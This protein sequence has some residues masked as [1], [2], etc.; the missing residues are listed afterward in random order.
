MWMIV[1]LVG[2]LSSFRIELRGTLDIMFDSLSNHIKDGAIKSHSDVKSLLNK[3]MASGLV[4]S[5]TNSIVTIHNVSIDKEKECN[6]LRFEIPLQIASDSYEDYIQRVKP[7]LSNISHYQS[8]SIVSQPNP[9]SMSISLYLGGIG[10]VNSMIRSAM[11]I[12]AIDNDSRYIT[13]IQSILCLSYDLYK[14]FFD[15]RLQDAVIANAAHFMTERI[16]QENNNFDSSIR[17]AKPC[18]HPHLSV[19]ILRMLSRLLKDKNVTNRYDILSRE[20]DRSVLKSKNRLKK[21]LSS[22][23]R[24]SIHLIRADIIDTI[25]ICVGYLVNQD[26]HGKAITRPLHGVMNKDPTYSRPIASQLVPKQSI[27]HSNSMTISMTQSYS[28]EGAVSAVAFDRWDDMLDGEYWSK[29]LQ[30]SV[31]IGV[32]L[33]TF[34]VKSDFMLFIFMI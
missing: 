33:R 18:A 10:H 30:Q 8:S 19:R 4:L 17:M 13:T 15:S 21:M 2:S 11:T 14:T 32:S 7:V 5:A 12:S 22:S 3:A 24:Q 25:S 16:H 20:E 29:Q 31:K 9:Q 6:D 1:I 27:N 28:N 23:Y 26:L 34:E